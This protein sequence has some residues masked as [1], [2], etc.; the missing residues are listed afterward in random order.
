MDTTKKI[1]IVE[2]EIDIREALA[3]MFTKYNFEVTTA[4]NGQEG[5]DKALAIHPDIIL[6]DLNMPVMNGHEA[7]TRLRNDPWGKTVKVV[8][9]SAL[10]DLDNLTEAHNQHITK[11]IVKAHTSLSAIVS[12]VLEVLHAE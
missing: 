10:D 4:V 5:L 6:L 7:L 8:V 12:N 1:L 2:D 11:Y 9:L 3:D